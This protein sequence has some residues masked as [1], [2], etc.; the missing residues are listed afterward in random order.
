MIIRSRAPL[1][2]GLAGGGTDVSPYC[3]QHGGAVLN[4]TIDQYAYTI[5]EPADDG[6]VTFTASDICQHYE[7]AADE[8][9]QLAD[10]LILHRAVYRRIVTQFN[11]GRPLPCRITTFCDAP[12]GSG[13]GTSSTIVVSMVKAFVEWLSLPLG[14]YEIAHLAFEIERIDAGL[15]GGRQDQYAATF[16]GVNFIEFHPDDRVIVNPLRIKNWIIS[17]METSLIL[18]DCGVSR[19]SA[20][21]I[22]EQ[23]DNLTN[24]SGTTLEAMHAIKEDAFRMKECLLKG[25]FERF[26]ANMRKSWDAK[27]QLATSVSNN[28]IDGIIEV[29][30]AS[31][32]RAGKV[33]GAGG[34]GFVTF[35]VA[36]ERRMD[37]IRALS[38][39]DGHVMICHFTRNGTEGWKIL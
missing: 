15:G 26:A 37:V 8:A 39:Q 36:P 20:R 2:L 24:E 28:Q 34:G 11:D 5:I 16:G 6:R 21:I 7:A 3:D 14:E 12:P 27:K 33:S 22:K 9:M 4:V 17:E 30:L 29:A 35:V 1:R 18:F 19:S 25:D 13:L 38:H 23:T 32:A 10:P 31:G